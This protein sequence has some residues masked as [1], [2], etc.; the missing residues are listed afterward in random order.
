MTKKI[1]K[2]VIINEFEIEISYKNKKYHIYKIENQIYV[3]I[4]Q[5]GEISNNK[6]NHTTIS[7]FINR[8]I[9]TNSLN[10]KTFKIKTRSCTRDVKLFT[11]HGFIELCE[12][13][14]NKF[15]KLFGIAISKYITK[16]KYE[17]ENITKNYIEIEDRKNNI[18]SI[19]KDIEI[20]NNNIE[21]HDTIIKHEAL[22]IMHTDKKI[23]YVGG[24][25]INIDKI[26]DNDYLYHYYVYILK[27]F[28]IISKDYSSEIYEFNKKRKEE[29]I[30][31]EKSG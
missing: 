6:T 27:T 23:N 12:K 26:I 11:N 3:S 13:T 14:K 21:K 19:V 4:N 5:I 15:I 29:K 24:T 28:K 17:N 30:R 20:I 7:R 8:N 22:I 10:F 31:S 16:Q 25:I 2:K 18:N 1:V 9:E